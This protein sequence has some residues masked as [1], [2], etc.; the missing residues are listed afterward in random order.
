MGKFL[1]NQGEQAGRFCL[2]SGDMGPAGVRIGE[3]G[4]EVGE[5]GRV[6]KRIGEK[7]PKGQGKR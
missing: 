2:A 1:W 5:V 6:Q 7:R 4:V 3:R